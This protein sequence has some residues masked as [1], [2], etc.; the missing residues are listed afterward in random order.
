MRSSTTKQPTAAEYLPLLFGFAVYQIGAAVAGLGVVE[1]LA[2]GPR[3]VGRLATITDT[4]PGHLR[5]LLRAA[6]AAQLLRATD[7]DAF[8]LTTL[9]RIFAKES[10]LQ[11]APLTA[12]HSAAP[13]WQAWGALEESVRTG[14]NAF[15]LA[16][17][18]RLFDFLKGEPELA[19]TFHDAMAA[20]SE[21]QLPA[22]ISGFDFSRFRHA[23]DVGGG[24]GTHLAA[25]L[26]AN[27]RL[28]GTVFD[29]ANGVVEAADVLESAGVAD[30]CEVVSG[31]FFDSVP[32]AADAYLLKNIL[33]DWNDDECRQ[34]LENCR[35]G[36]AP[37]GRIV[38][39]TSVLS[40]GR[41]D[42]DPAEALGA[43]IFDIEMMVMTTGR[44]RTLSEF[45]ALFAAPGLRLDTAT[46]LPCPFL[47]YALEA[48]PVER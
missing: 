20:G 28:R 34:I 12:M 5:R 48:V 42:E 11:A 2:D 40:E 25:I 1:A 31:S 39:F 7:D 16:H 13:V 33:H 3:T 32:A 26:A 15:E 10:P 4:H 47:Y 30:R 23:V 18:S 36:L 22:I 45:E 37:D 35:A 46:A 38:V 44:E 9:G 8:E 17:G 24:N 27:P 19:A 29:T 14:R 43:A 41:G 21:V 6:T